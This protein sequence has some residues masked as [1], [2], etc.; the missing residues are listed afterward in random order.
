MLGEVGGER[1]AG[2][3]EAQAGGR[4]GGG[5]GGQYLSLRGHSYHS[6]RALSMGLNCQP[7]WLPESRAAR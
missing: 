6:V 4:A 7:A 2:G 3:M 1:G 5:Q